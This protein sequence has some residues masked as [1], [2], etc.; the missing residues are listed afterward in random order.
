MAT[1][2][3]ARGR[4]QVIAE[5]L[6]NHPY[7]VAASFLLAA[8]ASAVTVWQFATG[9]D[10]PPAE[11]VV[12]ESPQVAP[13]SDLVTTFEPADPM[14]TQFVLPAS[15]PLDEMPFSPNFCTPE[16]LAWLADHGTERQRT[17]MLSIRSGSSG[18]S[19]MLAVTD[20]RLE[21]EVD[22]S[23]PA[24]PSFV[25]DCPSAG[26][27]D[28]VR[29][30][31]ELEDGAVVT[32]D[33]TGQPLAL[34]LAPGEVIQVELHFSGTSGAQ[35]PL[36]A[37]VA[38]GADVHTEVLVPEGEL[39]LPPLGRYADVVVALGTEP[40]M[41]LCYRADGSEFTDCDAAAIAQLVAAAGS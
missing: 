21:S 32:N 10:A 18:G 3:P 16:V 14:V 24:E 23:E 35:A 6:V 26:A 1:E 4:G 37:D 39:T 7:V 12:K 25:F 15:V 34:N 41:F 20:L 36:V 40:G 33:E 11:V 22:D 28:F 2:K 8:A 30:T 19:N 27:A 17:W 9:D 38:S 13:T 29:G 5:A 31:L